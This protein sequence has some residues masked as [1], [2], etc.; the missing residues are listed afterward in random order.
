MHIAAL[1]LSALAIWVAYGARTHRNILPGTLC[2]WLCG[3]HRAF[4]RHLADR[5]FVIEG[6]ARGGASASNETLALGVAL[7]V[8]PISGAFL[9][10]GVTF[11][12][13]E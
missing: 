8:F 10:T 11:P 1:I 6:L 13:Q 2:F 5:A 3:V 4:H 12:E 9:V 7:A